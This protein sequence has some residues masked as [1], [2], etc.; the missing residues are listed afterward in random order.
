MT[1]MVEGEKAHDETRR[2]EAALRAMVSNHGLLD[3]VQ[4]AL[5]LGKVIDRD[6]FLALDLA[7]ELDAAVHG[8]ITDPAFLQRAERDGAGAAIALGTALLRAAGALLKT[9]IVE[10]RVHG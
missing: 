3:G 5:A 6:D 1:R 8:L 9:Q 2:A 10:H 4:I 7:H